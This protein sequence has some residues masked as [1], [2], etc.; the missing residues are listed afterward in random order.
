[1]LIRKIIFNAIIGFLVFPLLLQIKRW[2]DFDVN[3]IEQYGSIKAIVLAFFIAFYFLNSTVFS[4]FILLPFQLIKDYYV[5]KGKKLSFLRKILWFSALVFALICVFGSFSNIWW[6]P[7]YKN[8][9]YIAYA[10]LL[11]LICTTLL[12]FMIDQY[13]EKTSDSG[14]S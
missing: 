3:L 7:W 1:M 8:M 13:I 14:K 10:L 5:T 2:G 4:I 12:Y 9:I 6:V 11:G